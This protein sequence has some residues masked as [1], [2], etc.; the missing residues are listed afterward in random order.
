MSG[1][2]LAYSVCCYAMSGSD[3][4]HAATPCPPERESRRAS[5]LSL[6]LLPLPP[7]LSSTPPPLRRRL[8]PR[9]GSVVTCADAHRPGNC[10]RVAPPPMGLRLRYA[11]S[12]SDLA[13]AATRCPEVT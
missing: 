2:E 5:H 13:Y 7:P 4:A 9:A 6:R 8:P 1:T 10:V 3:P 12:S 11:M